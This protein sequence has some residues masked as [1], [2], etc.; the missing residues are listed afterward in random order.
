MR[1][2]DGVLPPVTTEKPLSLEP[3]S[4]G[5]SEAPV[6]WED[7]HSVNSGFCR[8]SIWYAEGLSCGIAGIAV[9]AEEE[10]LVMKVMAYGS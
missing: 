5:L 8:Y 4:R 1:R 6:L 10:V 2:K 7:L 9:S 3:A